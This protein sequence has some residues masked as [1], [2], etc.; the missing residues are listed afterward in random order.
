MSAARD[1]QSHLVVVL[2]GCQGWVSQVSV[3]ALWECGHKAP[4]YTVGRSLPIEA[5]Q[6]AGCGWFAGV[7]VDH[8]FFIMSLVINCFFVGTVKKQVLFVTVDNPLPT[9]PSQTP[10]CKCNAQFHKVECS[11][12]L[13]CEKMF[14]VNKCL[15]SS[16]I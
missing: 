1:T 9:I 14:A 11:S 7:T 5:Q 8:G 2:L 4:A 12:K 6:A 15:Q 16:C 10:T 3:H 13:F